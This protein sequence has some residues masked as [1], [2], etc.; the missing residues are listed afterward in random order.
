MKKSLMTLMALLFLA[1]M[2]GT[3]Q[4][5]P[6]A[7]GG[8]EIPT[9]AASPGGTLI[10]SLTTSFNGIFGQ[11]AGT[12]TQN[13]LQNDTGM[14]FEYI[15]NSTG[16]GSITQVTA[17]FYGN[18]STD[19]DGPI[20]PHTPHVDVITRGTDGQTVSWSYIDDAMLNGESSGTLWVQTN[21]AWYT[22]GGFSLIGADT[23]TKVMYGP[24]NAVPEP[25][26]MLLLGSGLAGMFAARRK[27]SL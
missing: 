10:T 16:I 7:I 17:S 4:A 21:A 1:F 12:V 6:L 14:L 23:A 8:A 18:F 24:T 19:V 3:A 22:Q 5:V 26:S 27:K 11:I 15:V 13:V 20:F 25:A 9:G 2:S